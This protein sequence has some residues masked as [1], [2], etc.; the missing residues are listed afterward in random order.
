M[1]DFLPDTRASLT[2]SFWCKG[3][4]THFSCCIC[5]FTLSVTRKSSWSSGRVGTGKLKALLSGSAPSSL[6]RSGTT[7]VLLLMP[8]WSACW[9]HAPFCPESWIRPRDTWT[10]SPGAATH[11]QPGGVESVIFQPRI[12][13]SELEVLTLIP[14][15]LHLIA[16]CPS[17]CW[18]SRS[19]E[20]NRTMCIE[21]TLQAYPTL[22]ACHWGVRGD[23]F[24]VVMYQLQYIIQTAV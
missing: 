7:P 9:S 3:A 21:A 16:N 8:C 23:G 22:T 20:A 4:T 18:R 1:L 6:Q 13:A 24:F 12:I 15:A 10:S 11:F 14:T 2:G 17:G 5:N 19:V